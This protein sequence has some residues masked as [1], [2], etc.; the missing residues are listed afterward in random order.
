ILV[1]GIPEIM[2]G[3]TLA[4]SDDPRRLPVITVDEPSLSVT[5]GINP[6]PLAG[7]DG[8][9]LTASQVKARLDRELVGNVSLRV[10]QTERPELWEVQGG[11]ELARAGLVGLI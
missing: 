9:K 3:E 4:A 2:I 5:I 10:L 7:R 8:D 6:S 1:A 11:G